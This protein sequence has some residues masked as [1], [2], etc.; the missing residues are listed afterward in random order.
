MYQLLESRKRIKVGKL[1][2]PVL[3]EDEGLEVRYTCR[4]VRLNV[5]YAVLPK[6]QCAEAGLEGEVAELCDVVVREVN[7]VVVLRMV[8]VIV[9]ACGLF[10]RLTR[11]AP[12]FSM[13]EIL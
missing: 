6:E 4:E 13:A 7:C 11:A 2:E 10:W 1:R 5:R 12:M 9:T 8:L 3:C